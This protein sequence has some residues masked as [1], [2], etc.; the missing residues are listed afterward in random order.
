M[1]SKSRLV[2][3]ETGFFYFI[4]KVNKKNFEAILIKFVVYN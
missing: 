4:N 1:N 3:N 2:S